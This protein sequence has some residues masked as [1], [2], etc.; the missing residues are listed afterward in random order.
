MGTGTTGEAAVK[1]GR[2]FVG[3]EIDPQHFETACRR[4]EAA[5]RGVGHHKGAQPADGGLFAQGF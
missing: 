2:T 5:V 1:L 4:I 3:I